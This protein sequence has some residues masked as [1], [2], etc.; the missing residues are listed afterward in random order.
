MKTISNFS[1]TY[2]GTFEWSP[3]SDN[4]NRDFLIDTF[5]KDVN[6]IK[7]YNLLD[8]PTFNFHNFFNV[9]E[10]STLALKL[11]AVI[12]NLKGFVYNHMSLGSCIINHLTSL[13][14]Q[15]ITDFMWIQDDEFFVHN[16]FEDFKQFVDFYKT[17]EDI[18]H[19]NLLHPRKDFSQL[20][21][22]DVRLIPNTNINVS[23]FSSSE[24]KKVRIYSMDFTAFIC[25][26][27]Y[28][29]TNMFEESFI[30][31]LDA[32][33]LEGAVLHKSFDSNVERRFLDVKMFDSFNIVGMGG[34]VCQT[35]E[36]LQRL[37]NLY[38]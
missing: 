8:Y 36:T 35:G 9:E 16:S 10:A 20:E 19:V 25:N 38:T 3:G 37:K 26:I 12:P 28:F 21:S 23:C 30:N 33:K 18:K 2:R 27:D 1:Q 4:K 5:C 11:K 22:P 17:S 24:L 14:N 6:K 7:C 31:F 13:K 34:S 15:G 29:L 32:Y